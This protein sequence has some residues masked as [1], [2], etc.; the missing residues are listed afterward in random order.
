MDYMISVII[1]VYN[2]E[3]TLPETLDCLLGQ[4][5]Y[6]RCQIIIINDGS[7]D[8]SGI[9]A[10]DFKQKYNNVKYIFQE[11]KGVSAARNIGIEKAEGKYILFLD[12]D[13]LISRKDALEV[14]FNKMENENADAGVFRLKSFGYYGNHHSAAADKLASQKSIS[15]YDKNILWNYP[16][17]NKIY[18]ASIIRD[19]NHRF[20]DTT[21][22][23]DGAFWISFIMKYNPNIIGIFD[24][25]SEYRQSNPLLGKQVT[26]NIKLKTAE[27]F[28]KSSEIIEKSIIDS[29][30]AENCECENKDDFLNEQRLRVCQILID[31]FYRKAWQM[32]DSALEYIGKEYYKYANKLPDNTKKRLFP[33]D[34]II[35]GFTKKA[36]ADKPLLSIRA[37]NPSDEFIK[38]VYYQTTP[39]FEICTEKS[40]NREN[41]NKG[42]PKSGLCIRFKDNETPDPRL[43]SGILKIKDK[44][45]FLPSFLLKPAAEYYLR[46][47]D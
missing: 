19:N 14:L 4:S 24:A 46:L 39:C 42:K 12:A 7:T 38:A 31:G 45:T 5:V 32:D 33:T 1:P 25:V 17:S 22:T 29:F 41:I 37:K 2:N 10:E 36:I 23:E 16:V 20:P 9:I 8:N 15:R 44:F 6:N 47:K 30:N 28:I 34:L 3:N 40:I 27:D 26:Q 21:Y 43:L 13:D 35:S 11:N 18:R